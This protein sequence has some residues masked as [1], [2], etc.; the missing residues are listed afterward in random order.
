VQHTFDDFGPDNFH[1]VV[2]TRTG[3][4][5]TV[6]DLGPSIGGTTVGHGLIT[7][8]AVQISGSATTGVAGAPLGL[9]D[10]YQSSITY[11]TS[12]TY[13]YTT[14]ASGAVTD[15]G[16]TL[17]A[18]FRVFPHAVLTSQSTSQD[19]NYAF[20]VTGIRLNISAYTSGYACLRVIQ[21]GGP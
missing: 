7:G 11:A 19:G 4:T 20:P 15:I 2:A 6:T 21:G 12:T 13:T 10:G 3:T 1:P 5:V 17:A 9:L 16:T 18:N 8:D 14:T